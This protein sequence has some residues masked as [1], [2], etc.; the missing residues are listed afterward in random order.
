MW[1]FIFSFERNG[2]IS[3]LSDL[4]S[5]PLH[6]CK[7]FYFCKVKAALIHANFYCSFSH[8]YYY[9]HSD[10]FIDNFFIFVLIIFRAF[11]IMFFSLKILRSTACQQ[12]I[13]TEG[14]HMVKMVQTNV[15]LPLARLKC[16]P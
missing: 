7:V 13:A 8:Y 10:N 12:C 4:R 6:G 11:I 2:K 5:P 15:F 1:K 14:V 9:C 3:F 16:Y